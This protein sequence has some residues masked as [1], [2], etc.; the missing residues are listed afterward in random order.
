MVA[1]GAGAS[2]AAGASMAG[3]LKAG[4]FAVAGVLVLSATECGSKGTRS[5]ATMLMILI[6]GLTAGPA[7]SL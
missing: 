6:K 4:G 7:V 3:A 5:K 2:A 1:A